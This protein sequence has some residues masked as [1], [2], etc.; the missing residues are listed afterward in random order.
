MQI[1]LAAALLASLS[2]AVNVTQAAMKQQNAQGF[3]SIPICEPIQ[4]PGSGEIVS[5]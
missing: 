5:T 2:N 3:G 4:A 1:T